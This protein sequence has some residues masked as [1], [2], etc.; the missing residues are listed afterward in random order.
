MGVV[1]GVAGGDTPDICDGPLEIGYGCLLLNLFLHLVLSDLQLVER[2]MNVLE[3]SQCFI[4]G[5][6][7]RFLRDS[8]G[9]MFNRLLNVSIDVPRGGAVNLADDESL[10]AK[11]SER[12]GCFRAAGAQIYG[13]DG[14]HIEMRYSESWYIS[15]TACYTM[16]YTMLYIFH[17]IPLKNETR[18]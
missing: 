1:M 4:R 6:T 3:L 14:Y 11:N 17:L 9:Q 5:E 18:T 12:M 2:A 8:P 15:L 13:R 7:L 10:D 16:C